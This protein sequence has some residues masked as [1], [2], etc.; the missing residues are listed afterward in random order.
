[1]TVD[2]VWVVQRKGGSPGP[3][4]RPFRTD[5]DR[6]VDLELDPHRRP[7]ETGATGDVT[8]KGQPAR[9]FE[10]LECEPLRRYT[11]RFFLPGRSTM[12]WHHTIED[13]GNGTR[14]VTFRGGS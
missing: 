1:M 4:A 14:T 11:D 12:D 10:I 5:D 8:L 3:S 13:R 7:F 2:S 9:R 6:V